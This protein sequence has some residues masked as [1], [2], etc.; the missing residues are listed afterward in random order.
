MWPFWPYIRVRSVDNLT[1]EPRDRIRG[2]EGFTHAVAA[3]LDLHL[4]F[5]KPLRSNH[6]LPGNADQVGSGELGAGALVGI[7]IQY[8]DTPRRQLTI[9]FFTC[10]IGILAALLQVEDD[11][12][13]RG[14]CL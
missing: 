4:A 8:I 11:S 9:K 12:L 7:V 3:P 13:E 5:G 10:R 1:D 6:D 14:D 2:R